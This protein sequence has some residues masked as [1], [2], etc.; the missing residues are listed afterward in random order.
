MT[1][2]NEPMHGHMLFY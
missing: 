1:V 2:D